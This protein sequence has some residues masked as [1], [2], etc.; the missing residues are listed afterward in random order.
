VRLVSEGEVVHGWEGPCAL[1]VTVAALISLW[2]KSQ[3][4][5][6]RNCGVSAGIKARCDAGRRSSGQ[7]PECPRQFSTRPLHIA[8]TGFQFLS[9][10]LGHKQQL[11][12]VYTVHK[13]ASLRGHLV[14][15]QED[16]LCSR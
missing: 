8:R 14:V 16:E 10:A 12:V 4:Q 3:A 9:E 13:F 7:Y 1:E 11:C 15:H 6:E 5:A 2:K